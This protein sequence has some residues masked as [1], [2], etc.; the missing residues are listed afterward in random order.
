V[1]ADNSI[2]GLG[3]GATLG[4]LVRYL[5]PMTTRR[6]HV[7]Q[8][9]GGL[10]DVAYTSPFSI[11]QEACAKLNAEGTYFAYPAMVLSRDERDS[12]LAN[13]APGKKMKAMWQECST[14]IFGVGA[15]EAGYLSS[16]L[17]SREELEHHKKIGIV[18]DVLG[19]CFD[20]HGEFVPTEL[21]GRL[22]SIPLELLKRVPERMAVAGGIEKAPALKA[23]LSAGMTTTLFIDD[24]TAKKVLGDDE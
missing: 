5:V 12:I 6:V 4:H 17:V 10:L 23:L 19:H 2:L 15:A 22:M 16:Q 21:S 13:S 18:G 20:R 1:V 14:A 3:L 24:R 7:V 8:L 11:V 9:I